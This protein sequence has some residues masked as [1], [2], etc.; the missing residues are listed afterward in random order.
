MIKNKWRYTYV[1]PICPHDVG[2][3]KFTYG[4]EDTMNIINILRCDLLSWCFDVLI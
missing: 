2:R 4:K 3:E 1:P